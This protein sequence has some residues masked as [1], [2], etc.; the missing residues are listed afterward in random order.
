MLWRPTLLR[1][2][3][4]VEMVFNFL[5]AIVCIRQKLTTPSPGLNEAWKTKWCVKKHISLSKK[6]KS[7]TKKRY[8]AHKKS[9]FGRTLPNWAQNLR[10]SIFECVFSYILRKLWK[11]ASKYAFSQILRP[12]RQCSSKIA[13]L[14]AQYRFFVVDFA[15]FDKLVC[16][17][18][19]PFSFSRFVKAAFF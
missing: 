2:S 18:Y 11:N 8:W 16:F 19:A 9:D 14:C 5:D 4:C 3:V 13:F 1:F 7:T 6:A 12:V 15:F 17:F 10:K